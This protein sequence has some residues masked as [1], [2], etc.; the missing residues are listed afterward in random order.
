MATRAEAAG[1]AEWRRPLLAFV[2]DHLVWGILAAILF[3]C[4]V[5]IEHFFQVGIFINILQHAT[6]VGLLA[7]GLSFCIVAGHMD[8]SIE[9][10]MAFAA[11]LAAWLTA[12]RGSPLGFQLNTWVTF[13]DRAGLRRPGRPVQCGPGR[14]L[15]DQRLHRDP[16]HLHLRPWPRPDPDR[17][18][19]DVRPA[20]RLPRRRQ[21]RPPRP[22]AC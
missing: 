7:I 18:A 21:R 15:Q 19:L 9:S 13:V 14:P 3:V 11:M 12:T 5:T 17:R 8:L 4:S 20:R 6:F 1:G 22:A 16:G 2:L 10:V